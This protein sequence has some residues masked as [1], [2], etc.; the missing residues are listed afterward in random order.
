MSLLRGSDA[1]IMGAAAQLGLSAK[2][3]PVWQASD[4]QYSDEE[5]DC[6]KEQGEEG[7]SGEECDCPK[8]CKEEDFTVS[9]LLAV[10]GPLGVHV[11]GDF[12]GHECES[13]AL[14]K[15]PKN[16][17]RCAR[18]A[19]GIFWVHSEFSWQLGLVGMGWGNEPCIETMQ[20]AAALIITVPPAPERSF[21]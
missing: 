3:E 21:A 1:A 15:L 9:P 10:G 7:E 13:D 4:Y 18:S 6:L 5:Y 11:A 12:G 16:M 20:S 14:S 2:V 8:C 17:R 19:T